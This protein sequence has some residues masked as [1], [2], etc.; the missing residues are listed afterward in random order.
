MQ[1][2]LSFARVSPSA[3]YYGERYFQWKLPCEASEL[4][5]FRH[6]IGQD[7]V[8]KILKMMV[9]LHAEKVKQADEL[10]ADTTVQEANVKF[11]NDTR[12]HADCIEKLWRLGESESVSWRRS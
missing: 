9:A 1:Y 11:R 2:C 8:E 12:L 5:H 4:V 6:R 7:G 10:E 3:R